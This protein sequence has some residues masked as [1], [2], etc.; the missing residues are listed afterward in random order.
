MMEI[1]YVTTKTYTLTLSEYELYKLNQILIMHENSATKYSAFA[2]TFRK[3]LDKPTQVVSA[4][5]CEPE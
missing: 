5:G 2:Q 3:Q 1:S 4:P